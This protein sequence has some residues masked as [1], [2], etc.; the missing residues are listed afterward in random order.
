MPGP[1]NIDL[2]QHS[3]DRGILK[4]STIPLQESNLIQQIDTSNFALLSNTL[5]QFAVVLIYDQ[6]TLSSG[7]TSITKI[8][9]INQT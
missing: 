5:N 7:K 3:A 8:T 2:K 4:R 6:I 1:R 9:P